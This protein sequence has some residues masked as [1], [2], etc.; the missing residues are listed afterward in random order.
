MDSITDFS[1]NGRNSTIGGLPQGDKKVKYLKNDSPYFNKAF[2]V[3][4]YE[5]YSIE[6]M[7]NF[8]ISNALGKN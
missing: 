7:V 4:F 1:M 2:S 3:H 6:G 8:D 5:S